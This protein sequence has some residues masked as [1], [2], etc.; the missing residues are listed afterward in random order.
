MEKRDAWWMLDSARDPALPRGPMIEA[1]AYWAVAPGVGEVRAE[2]IPPPAV[3]EVL[4]RALWSGVSRGTEALVGLGRV[5]PSQWAAMRA[6]FQAGGFPFPVKYGY[7]SVGVVE[8]GPSEL[9]GRAV[10][11]LYPHQ[12]RYVVPAS[13]VMPLPPGLPSERAVLAANMETALNAVWDAA[14]APGQRIHVIGAGVVGTMIAYLCGRLPGAE[15]TLADIEPRR[16]ALAAALGAAFADPDAL[17]GSAD[18]VLH[19]SGSPAGLRTALAVAGT[20]ARVVEVSWYGSAEVPLPLG[21]AFHSRRLALIGSQVGQVAPAMRPRWPHARRLA[22]ALEL[23]RDPALDSLVSAEVA[24]AELPTVL[25][26]LA[27][28]PAGA[29]CVRIAYPPA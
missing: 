2:R 3:G 4:V 1:R 23:L 24:F 6:P 21:E 12:T 10:F 28:E 5:P 22:K 18:L 27:V 15:V 16:S 8:E 13:G 17:A 9:V 14:A 20:E 25:P 11:C 26:R 29:L 7:S 19:A